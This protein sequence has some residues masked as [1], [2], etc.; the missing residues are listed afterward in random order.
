MKPNQVQER[1]CNII[2]VYQT[3]KDTT[4]RLIMGAYINQLSDKLE[5]IA[6]GGKSA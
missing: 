6:R 3:E 5:S 4:N 1:V 2:R